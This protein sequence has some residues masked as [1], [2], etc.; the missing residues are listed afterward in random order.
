MSNE[1]YLSGTQI[2]SGLYT[3]ILGTLIFV[4]GAKPAW[5]GIDRSPVVGF[6]QIIVFLIGLAI[7]C[8]GGYIGLNALWGDTERSMAADFGFR[9][10]AT[11]YVI[12]FFAGM[13]DLFGMGT[14]PLPEIPF[15]GPV[16]TIGMEIGQ[17]LILLGFLLAVR[18]KK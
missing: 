10:A 3:T 13:A 11:G 15:F 12:A 14:H 16:Q 4:L 7:I 17:G 9:F 8:V 6:V 5:F 1:T 18:Y 2:R